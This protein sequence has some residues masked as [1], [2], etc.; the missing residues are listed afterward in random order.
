MTRNAS[1]LAG[2]GEWDPVVLRG[3]HAVLLGLVGNVD[4]EK[5][6]ELDEAAMASTPKGNPP[7]TTRMK[8]GRG[9]RKG[10]MRTTSW[11]WSAALA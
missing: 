1:E 8:T 6:F 11:S 10:R 2:E 9:S 4:P 7:T 3:A 5:V